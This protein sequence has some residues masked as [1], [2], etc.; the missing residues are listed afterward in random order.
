MLISSK[1][2]G[3]RNLNR[4]IQF[5][6][7]SKKEETDYLNKVLLLINQPSYLGV[8]SEAAICFEMS[9]TI[10]NYIDKVQYDNA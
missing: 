9:L 2:L 6:N 7:Y 4:N 1:V 3:H 5:L 10:F 8:F